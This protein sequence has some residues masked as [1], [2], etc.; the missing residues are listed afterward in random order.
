MAGAP[1]VLAF[2]A[3]ALPTRRRW[4]RILPLLAGCLAIVGYYVVMQ[5]VRGL[6]RDLTLSAFAAT[7][8]PNV[9][10]LIL[11]VAITKLSAQQD[12]KATLA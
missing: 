10:V 1:F 4:G 5:A 8:T 12:N 11:S 6:G 3:V 7:S 9:A 2:F